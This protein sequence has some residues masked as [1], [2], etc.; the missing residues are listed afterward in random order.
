MTFIALGLFTYMAFFILI[1]GIGAVTLRRKWAKF[2]ESVYI[3]SEAPKLEYNNL[4]IGELFTFYGS[5]ES[6]KSDD[7]LWL[8]SENL[9]ICI[10]LSDQEVYT[11]PNGKTEIDKSSWSSVSSIIEGTQFYVS[12]YLA[13]N[14]GVPYLVGDEN[15]KLLVVICDNE[16]KILEKLLERGRN[17]NEMW[18]SYSPYSYITGIFVLI[19]LSY[20]SYR[21]NSDKLESYFL[22]LAAG[23]PFY[24]ILPPGLFFYLNY[25]RLWDLS[26][27]W[28]ILRDLKRLKDPNII[29]NNFKKI[30]KSRE[31]LSLLNYLLGYLLNIIIA[32]IILYKMFE[33]IIAN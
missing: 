15:S 1:P 22:L 32:G 2:R 4:V 26:V 28:S 9:S 13:Y 29:S 25:R 33:Y 30:S 20:F 23:T 27:R 16:E 31:R 21:T 17:K 11:I 18:N 5:L 24:F 7:I 6:F 12:G 3:S 8:K 19:I 10:D 14:K